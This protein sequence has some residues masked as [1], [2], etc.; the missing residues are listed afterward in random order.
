LGFGP[1]WKKQGC[2]TKIQK[3][4]QDA[5]YP[6][7]GKREN[8]MTNQQHPAEKEKFLRVWAFRNMTKR[9]AVGWLNQIGKRSVESQKE[10]RENSA[11]C[12]F[13]VPASKENQFS[14]RVKNRVDQRRRYRE[15]RKASAVETLTK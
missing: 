9:Q 11:G 8:V 12:I 2:P 3:K 10:M 5:F 13:R 7:N 15:T 1:G 14:K 6:T 4:R